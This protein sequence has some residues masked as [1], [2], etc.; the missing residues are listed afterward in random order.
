[1]TGET[2]VWKYFIDKIGNAFG[3][4]GLL[5]N[6]YAESGINPINLENTGNKRL[7][8]TDQE[9]TDKVDNG[10]YTKEQFKSDKFGYGLAQ[11]TYNTRKANLYT[12]CKNHNNG[13]IGNI[14][15]QSEFLWKELQKYTGVLKVLKSA[16]SIRE[17]S[18]VVLTKFE[19]PTNQGESVKK[20]R[21]EYGKKIYDRQTKVTNKV[22]NTETQIENTVSTPKIIMKQTLRK[23]DSNG[24]VKELQKKL[25]ELGYDLGKAGADGNF[26]DKTEVA[27]KNFQRDNQLVIDGV[28]GKKTWEKLL[29]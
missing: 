18:D 9:Y 21:A 8:L 27:V 4:A 13:S 28:V 22:T 11:W 26:G 17:A 14:K 10:S 3:V 2:F 6:L 15:S 20:K 1:M 19:R 7:C 16:K 24:E 23:G 12:Y 5:G 25:I 29:G